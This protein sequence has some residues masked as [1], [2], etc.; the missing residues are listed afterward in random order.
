MKVYV[1]FTFDQS[2]NLV[3]LLY[4]DSLVIMIANIILRN[5]YH[6]FMFL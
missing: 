3:A 4:Y 6:E 5:I 2:I 1:T